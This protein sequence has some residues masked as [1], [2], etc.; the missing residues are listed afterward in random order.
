MSLKTLIKRLPN[1]ELLAFSSRLNH[2]LD[3]INYPKKPLLRSEKL[4]S[5]A[6][7]SK[8]TAFAWL[9]GISLPNKTLCEKI[10]DKFVIDQAWLLSGKG[11]PIC[12]QHPISKQ[13]S[14]PTLDLTHIW[15][16]RKH[17]TEG[18]YLNRIISKD[19]YHTRCFAVYIDKELLYPLYSQDSY[20]IINPELE[21]EDRDIIIVK[22]A[23][24][25]QTICGYYVDADDMQFILPFNPQTTPQ[26][27][28]PNDK[29]IGP[30]VATI[31]HYRPQ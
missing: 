21:L 22:L 19:Y 23:R 11:A 25:G 26:S 3:L 9:N 6:G 16:Y 5:F 30:V 8:K 2:A 27:L 20:C 17:L 13:V 15:Q 29:I 12:G 4:A 28:L 7:V 24:S 10:A 14:L 18:S 1:Q 31:T